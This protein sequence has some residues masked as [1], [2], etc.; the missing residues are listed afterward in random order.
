VGPK[1]GL[2]DMEKRRHS[3]LY[4]DSNPGPSRPYA[5]LLWLSNAGR[6]KCVIQNRV[7]KELCTQ[8]SRLLSLDDSQPV[9]I[10]CN[11]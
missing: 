3:C 5:T 9:L 4:R 2:A 1:T 8:K 6:A 10:L 11:T 7:F